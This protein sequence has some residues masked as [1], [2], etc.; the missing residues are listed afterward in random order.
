MHTSP[1]VCKV[2]EQAPKTEHSAAKMLNFVHI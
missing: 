2:A 1:E